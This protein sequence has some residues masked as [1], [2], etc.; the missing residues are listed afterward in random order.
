MTNTSSL[1]KFHCPK[2]REFR[3]LLIYSFET[4]PGCLK[5]PHL[6]I[7]GKRWATEITHCLRAAVGG[8]MRREPGII[9]TGSAQVLICANNP[10]FKF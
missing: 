5:F 7:M 10:H 9:S 2:T 4:L 3:I 8:M 6:A 1:H